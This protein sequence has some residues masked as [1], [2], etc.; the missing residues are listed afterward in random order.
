MFF[1]T[2]I[3]NSSILQQNI[4][5]DYYFVNTN[6]P[7]QSAGFETNLKFVY[8]ENFKFFAGY[9]FTNAKATYINGNQ[10]LTL[11]PKNKLNLAL[12]YE[13]EDKIRAQFYSTIKKGN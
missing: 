13:K 7:V 5:A 9:T 8:K 2:T 4:A 3:K 1:Y 11:L 6:K 12:V 10:F